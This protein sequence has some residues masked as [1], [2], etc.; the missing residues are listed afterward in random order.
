MAQSF[1]WPDALPIT[2][3]TASKHW[4]QQ[5]WPNSHHVISND[6]QQDHQG[7]QSI[8]LILSHSLSTTYENS[9]QHTERI[10]EKALDIDEMKPTGL[11][12]TPT[13]TPE[14]STW[15][16]GHSCGV[17]H[18]LKACSIQPANTCKKHYHDNSQK[19]LLG[20][21]LTPENM[22]QLHKT[23]YIHKV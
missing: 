15:K 7:W 8:F 17:T 12:T 18:T 23:V 13:E 4:R 5:V 10:K 21:S 11:S 20:T 6:T 19:L 1:Y 2:Q 3:P 9:G 22:G 16:F 14:V